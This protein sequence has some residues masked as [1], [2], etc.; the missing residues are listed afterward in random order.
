M[1]LLRLLDTILQT[2]LKELVLLYYLPFFL[3][4][5]SKHFNSED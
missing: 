1:K 5:K 4:K 2:N 3:N